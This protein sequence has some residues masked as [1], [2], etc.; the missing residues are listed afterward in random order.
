LDPLESVA[1]FHVTPVSWLVTITLAPGITDL[2][3]SETTPEMRPVRF[4]ASAA[5][6]PNKHTPQAIENNN[7]RDKV[8]LPQRPGRL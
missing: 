7:L 8:D 2:E 6:H 4:W 5:P 3:T 1:A